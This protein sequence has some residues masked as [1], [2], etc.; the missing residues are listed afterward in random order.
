MTRNKFSKTRDRDT[1]PGEEYSIDLAGPF[2]PTLFGGAKYFFNLVDTE[3][4]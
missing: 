2:T 1:K 4:N 3:R